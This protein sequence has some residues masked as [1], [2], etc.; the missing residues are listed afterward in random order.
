MKKLKAIFASALALVILSSSAIIPA[1]ASVFDK[2]RLEGLDYVEGEAVVVLKD[3]ASSI[4][5][6][7]NKSAAAYGS[8]VKLKNTFEI[9]A[10]ARDN[11]SVKLAVVKSDKLS[12]VQLIDRLEG[13]SGIDYVV[14]NF[15]SK[16]SSITSDTYSAFQWALENNG[17]N[18]GTAGCDIH[19]Q[20]LWDK[21]K[22]SD[23]E[24]LVAVIDT[25]IDF[26]H[27]DLQD[28]IWT[29]PYGSKLIGEHGY[30]FTGANRD[31]RPRDD[32]GHGTHVSG[33]IAGIGDNEKGISGI[34][35][36][37]VKILPVKCFDADG[38]CELDTEIASFEYLARAVK[39][40]AKVDAV[41]CSFGGTGD[42]SE[43][44]LLE[45]IFNELEKKGVIIAVAA[46]NDSVDISEEQE[47][48]IFEESG[49]VLPA[50]VDCDNVIVVGA[51]NGK[52][53][54]ASYSN[55]SEKYVDVAAPGSCILST[56]CE[57]CFN[58]SIYTDEQKAQ[59]VSLLPDYNGE[60][61]AGDAG[62]PVV[63][64]ESSKLYPLSRNA[65]VSLTDNYFGT[66]GKAVRVKFTDKRIELNNESGEEEELYYYC[67][68]IPFS[69]ENKNEKYSLSFMTSS[70]KDIQWLAVDTTADA[71]PISSDYDAGVNAMGRGYGIDEWDHY[72]IEVDPTKA[73]G[74]IKGTERKLQIYVY[75]N[76]GDEIEI[77]DFAV[78]KQGVDREKFGKYDFYGGTSMA[79][80]YVAGAA[81]LL[82]RAYPDAEAKD[83][84]AMIK[85]SGRRS[86]ALEG[87][88]ENAM[89]LSLENTDKIPPMITS[90]QFSSNGK[91]VVIK[92]RLDGVTEIKV[93]G[94]VVAPKS[95]TDSRIV[96]PDNNYNVKDVT[97]TVTN[98]L[99]SSRFKTHLTKQKV[100]PEAKNVY[101]MPTATESLFPVNAGDKAFFVDRYT[102]DI[103]VLR[104]DAASNSYFCESYGKINIKKFLEKKSEVN[105]D[106]VT[107][108]NGKIYFAAIGKV[109]SSTGRTLGYDNIFGCYDVKAK[110]S[111]KLCALPDIPYEGAS[112][113]TLGSGF[114]LMGGYDGAKNTYSDKVYKYNSSKK[115]FTLLSATLPEGRA[116]ARY[117]EYNGLIVGAYGAQKDGKMPPIITF[118]GKTFKTS[119]VKCVSDDKSEAESEFAGWIDIYD[120]N[121]GLGKGG[122]FLNGA[123]IDG[124]GD[125]FIYNP[126]TD[127]ATP[128]EYI[129]SL[130]S[131]S[132]KAVFGVT[133]PGCFIAFTATTNELD[134][135]FDFDIFSKKSD[136]DDEDDDD[137]EE[138]V[139]EKAYFVP[140]KNSKNI[141]YE[142]TYIQKIKNRTMYVGAS[143]TVKPSIRNAKGKTKYLSSNSKVV[144]V[145]SNGKLKALRK[146]KAT[147]TVRNNGVK[148]SFTV[149]VRNPSLNKSQVSLKKGKS[150]ALRVT[151]K[152]GR[153][154]F[155]SSD[156]K[157][158]TVSSAGRI[159][160]VGRGKATVTVKTNGIELLCKVTVK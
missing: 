12:T 10:D 150:F 30:D 129:T 134:D 146:G 56:V 108:K 86:E 74:Y 87:K 88:V 151:G 113:V 72:Q 11:D 156:K 124:L 43:K 132:N 58:P 25:G 51:T 148:T 115:S 93:N 79:T 114:Y 122:V 123:F 28:L 1:S 15:K 6:N 157:V 33:I 121:I 107:Y 13:R 89:S 4:Y 54:L 61:K 159:K 42:N 57:N 104:Y 135:D 98:E 35:K 71:Q 105:Y 7:K 14:P 49:L 75:A 22:D 130:I 92:G 63:T 45:K 117:Y 85:L 48:G 95:V 127:K 34:N 143:S 82:K 138:M 106:G 97:I 101:G 80:P 78:S 32:N 77:D 38:E 110:K 8:G 64:A 147:I 24:S 40:G 2:N 139:V 126:K 68:E 47:G 128:A 119:T 53:E 94:E 145:A 100:F 84:I 155:T 154:T 31:G 140:L 3:N 67:F 17:Q 9:D 90:A 5:T 41:N 21:T 133:L 137:E 142:Q 52:D 23:S 18:N 125:T 65:E 141:P 26:E 136:S 153:A 76:G 19:P 36:K 109:Q 16:I 27:E 81:A 62:Y 131:G 20:T 46:G 91:S 149:T 102:G 96:I 111:Y 50:R 69:I 66:S 37:G 39:L 152:V 83:I 120:G 70:T 44:K 59:L 99:G 118:D 29:N 158:A 60:V 116:F 144:K 103:T 160:A 55:Y 73:K 112:L